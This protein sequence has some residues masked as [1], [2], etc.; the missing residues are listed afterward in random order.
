MT[1]H[2][3]FIGGNIHVKEITEN[4][5]VLE[6][7]L[8]DTVQDWFY[9]AFCVEGAQGKEITFHFQKNRLGYWGPAVSHDLVHWHW[10][11]SVDK[12][13]F[14]YRFG[15][16][17]SRVYFAHS[18]LY[19]PTR[20]L[21]FAA[22]KGLKVTELCQ[23]RKGRSV[24]CLQMGNGENSI[25]LTA[26]HH[27]CESTGN[28]VLEGVLEELTRELPS[29]VRLLCVPFVDFDGVSDGDQGK[30]RAPHDHNRDYSYDTTPIYPEVAAI[31]NQSRNDSRISR[32]DS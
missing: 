16:N 20:F 10:L 3:N 14:T 19:H 21:D 4:T 11:D 7:E 8:R 24:P 30:S 27:A 31:M 22:Q 28:Y 12:D 23:S 6:N 29:G 13:S 26:R 9:W 25:I 17:E 5:V 1:I 15:E 32:H 2:Q 18:M